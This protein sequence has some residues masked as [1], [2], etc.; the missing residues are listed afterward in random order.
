VEQLELLYYVASHVSA[1]L[2]PHE[3]WGRQWG[4]DR[5]REAMERES[6]LALGQKVNSQAY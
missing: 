5:V 1:F 6:L 3:R 4:A 2:W